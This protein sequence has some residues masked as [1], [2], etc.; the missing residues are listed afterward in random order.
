M[1]AILVLAEAKYPRAIKITAT[2]YIP[3]TLSKPI[4]ST[5]EDKKTPFNL[6][7]IIVTAF[8]FFTILAFFT[9]LLAAFGFFARKEKKEDKEDKEEVLILLAFFLIWLAI[10]IALYIYC[11]KNK[12]LYT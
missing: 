9:F 6:W 11:D 12:C 10:L 7:I 4:S 5:I 1:G 8:T 2:K 3:K